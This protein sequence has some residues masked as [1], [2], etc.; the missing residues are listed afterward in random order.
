[1]SIECGEC[2]RD[3]RGGH[4]SSCSR[5]KPP[6]PGE[7][8]RVLSHHKGEEFKYAARAKVIWA[9]RRQMKVE[10]LEDY[11]CLSAGDTMRAATRMWQDEDD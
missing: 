2:E 7:V 9:N 5:W 10:L 4:D 1:M 3:L 8:G 11:Y 6:K